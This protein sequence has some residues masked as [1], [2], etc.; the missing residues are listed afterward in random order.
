[1]E[2]GNEPHWNAPSPIVRLFVKG[3]ANWM[4]QF[5]DTNVLRTSRRRSK[6]GQHWVRV[7][8]DQ[9]QWNT[10][11]SSACAALLRKSHHPQCCHG[12][13]R[14]LISGTPV[15]MRYVGEMNRTICCLRARA[16]TA[17][18]IQHGKS[19]DARSFSVLCIFSVVLWSP[20]RRNPQ[21]EATQHHT[22]KPCVLPLTHLSHFLLSL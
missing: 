16:A 3:S 1:M 19:N 15:I 13:T 12:D 4:D 14:N 6:K 11:H 22:T 5:S 20:K 2:G 9:D 7:A 18:Y 10:L 8:E 21:W 17:G